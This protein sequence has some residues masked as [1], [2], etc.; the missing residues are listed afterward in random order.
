MIQQGFWEVLTQIPYTV[1]SP[2]GIE[3]S[4]KYK[5]MGEKVW[6]CAFEG[7]VLKWQYCIQYI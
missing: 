7:S 1:C 6:D 4:A 5:I 3:I 2:I